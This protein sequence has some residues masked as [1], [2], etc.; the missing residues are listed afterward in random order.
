[1]LK[2]N[3]NTKNHF[4][5]VRA[6][7]ILLVAVMTLIASAGCSSGGE[8]EISVPDPVVTSAPAVTSVGPGTA[9]L[10]TGAPRDT[11]AEPEGNDVNVLSPERFGESFTFLCEN[12]APD[13]FVISQNVGA[14]AEKY[15]VTPI[16]K[17]ADDMYSAVKSAV[18]SGNITDAD[19]LLPTV[20]T[21][22]R[23]TVGG[24]L[25]DLSEAGIGITPD[26][27]GIN[28]A[29]T[30]DVNI[31]G[32]IYMLF[33]EGLTSDVTASYGVL[34]RPGLVG[35]GFFYDPPS[36][37][38]SGEWSVSDFITCANYAGTYASLAGGSGL[39][40]TSDSTHRLMLLGALGGN[41]YTA[42]ANGQPEFSSVAEGSELAGAYSAALS[43]LNS[44]NPPKPLKTPVMEIT[45]I[46]SVKS[47]EVYLPL[48]FIDGTARTPVDTAQ[49]SVFAAPKGIAG[50]KRTAAII[51]AWCDVVGSGAR[52]ELLRSV[53]SD[54]VENGKAMTDLIFRRQTADPALL[55]GWGDFDK[56][57][58]DGLEA[59]TSL[60]TLTE[61]RT[62]SDRKQA[63]VTAAG[64]VAGR[65]GK[66]EE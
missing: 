9:G 29:L 21:A 41:L 53:Y 22:M 35:V 47:G 42:G 37:I 28:S 4:L 23:L 1:M 44:V 14:V 24:Y 60:K 5:R 62:F 56:L 33:C 7:A 43:L 61:D 52:R 63:L 55:L 13:L 46:N 59:R 57:I 40:M 6:A 39:T 10:H 58:S 27:A 3:K 34:Y 26:T 11:E 54:A 19:L 36:M 49:C 45:R 66:S 48:P 65:L 50:G 17:G 30:S 25:Q 16:L 8:T 51:A 31:F 20:A 12:T 2:R 38:F 64:I 32:G 18:D 15:G